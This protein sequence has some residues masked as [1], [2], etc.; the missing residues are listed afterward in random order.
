MQSGSVWPSLDH[1]LRWSVIRQFQNFTP[2]INPSTSKKVTLEIHIIMWNALESLK[3]SHTQPKRKHEIRP[4]WS[5]FQMPNHRVPL[6]PPMGEIFTK[7][8]RMPDVFYIGTNGGLHKTIE[9]LVLFQF[10]QPDS[11]CLGL[12]HNTRYRDLNNSITSLPENLNANRK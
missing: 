12:D 9:S 2:S 4:I 1:D 7:G 10:L 8:N 11:A 3:H 5:T 6:I